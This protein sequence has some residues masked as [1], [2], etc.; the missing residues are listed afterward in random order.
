MKK[1][2]KLTLFWI[3]QVTWGLLDNILGLFLFIALIARYG[4][5]KLF[6]HKKAD[7]YK[8]QRFHQ[9][10]YFKVGGPAW[11]GFNCGFVAVTDTTPTNKLLRH[12]HGHFIQNFY[13][14]PFMPF[15]Q[16]ASAIR[17]GYR[18]YLSKHNPKKYAMLPGYYDIWFEKQASELG[19]KYFLTK[20]LA[21]MRGKE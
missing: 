2:L 4:F 15:I 18:K 11:G 3:V 16:L 5:A 10:I 12:E 9:M 19:D 6:K 8:P 13:F 17:Y 7:H 21:K 20:P 1:A 14:G